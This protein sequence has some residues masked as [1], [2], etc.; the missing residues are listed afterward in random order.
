MSPLAARFWRAWCRSRRSPVECHGIPRGSGGSW[1]SPLVARFWRAWRRSRRSPVEC[2]GMPRRG[3]AAGFFDRF[4]SSATEAR[5]TP[6]EECRLITV[7]ACD[8]DF[9]VSAAGLSAACSGTCRC[10][11]PMP[12]CIFRSSPY[13]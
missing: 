1:M 8:L 4:T 13:E 9:F 2:H 10:D 6:D 7:G 12:F 11:K 3:S 5:C